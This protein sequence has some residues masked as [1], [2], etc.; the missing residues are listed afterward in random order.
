MDIPYWTKYS[1]DEIKVHT[2]IGKYTIRHTQAQLND[3][4]ISRTF[5]HVQ[6]SGAFGEKD[7]Y[8]LRRGCNTCLNSKFPVS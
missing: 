1:V 4:F 5:L 8:P 2:N 6:C 7:M 3:I